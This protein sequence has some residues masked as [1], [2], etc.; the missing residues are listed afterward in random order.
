M[1]WSRVWFN[2]VNQKKKTSQQWKWLVGMQRCS[3]TLWLW[4]Q[5]SVKIGKCPKPWARGWL[6][7]FLPQPVHACACIS[8]GNKKSEVWIAV[9]CAAPEVHSP[10]WRRTLLHYYCSNAEQEEQPLCQSVCVLGSRWKGSEMRTQDTGVVQGGHVVV[11]VV[12]HQ[13]WTLWCTQQQRKQARDYTAAAASQG[14][15]TGI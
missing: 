1:L 8:Q 12:A 13:Q 3:V 10:P 4:T 14:S 5:R 6:L 15:D 7:S 11:V 9:I 2:V